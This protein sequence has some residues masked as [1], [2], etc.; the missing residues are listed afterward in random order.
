M[1]VFV[2]ASVTW[3][4]ETKRM[5]YTKSTRL[6]LLCFVRFHCVFFTVCYVTK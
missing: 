3:L 6:A 1:H 2:P 4:N 5:E